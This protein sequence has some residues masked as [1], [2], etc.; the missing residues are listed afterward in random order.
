[1]YV[2]R[3]PKAGEG[4]WEAEPGLFPTVLQPIGDR[5]EAGG[6]WQPV[7][8]RRKMRREVIVWRGRGL[9]EEGDGW[10]R[11]EVMKDARRGMVFTKIPDSINLVKTFFREQEGI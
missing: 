2:S 7:L 1:M 9:G 10:V 4:R 3:L 5:A 8:G 6:A 11:R